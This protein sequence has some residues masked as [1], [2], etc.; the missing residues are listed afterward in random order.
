[1]LALICRPSGMPRFSVVVKSVDVIEGFLA[2]LTTRRAFSRVLS[3]VH[4]QATFGRVR[5]P[6]VRA[7]ERTLACVGSH[8]LHQVSVLLEGF[9]TF[10][11]SVFAA[12]ND[13]NVLANR[14]NKNPI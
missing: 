1:M 4:F 9:G 8:V 13:D 3:I 5:L 7:L 2:L 10:R 11:A 6:A 14:I 12:Y